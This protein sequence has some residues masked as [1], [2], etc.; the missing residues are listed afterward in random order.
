[1]MKNG[2]NSSIGLTAVLTRAAK[3]EALSFYW[4]QFLNRTNRCSDA[5]VS[6]FSIKSAS[7]NSSIGLTAVL[8]ISLAICS[9]STPTFQFLNRTNRCSDRT[10]PKEEGQKR[11]FQF[12]NRTNRCS[13]ARCGADARGIMLFQFLNRTNRCSD[14]ALVY[15][16]HLRLSVSIPQSD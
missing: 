2:F 1:M 15:S 8:T 5:P 11:R 13:D 12:L 9:I 16:P 3:L 10:K 6:A 7:F 14:L 4:F